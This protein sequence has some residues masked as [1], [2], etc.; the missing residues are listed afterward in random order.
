MKNIHFIR[1]GKGDALKETWKEKE[2]R[3]EKRK[4]D[5]SPIIALKTLGI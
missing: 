1:K 5:F 2:E 3:E 4:Q